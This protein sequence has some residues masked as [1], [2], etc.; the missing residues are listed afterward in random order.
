MNLSSFME[1]VYN[2]SLNVYCAFSICCDQKHVCGTSSIYVVIF[3]PLLVDFLSFSGS[4]GWWVHYTGQDLLSLGSLL[5]SWPLAGQKT[6]S[7]TFL[8]LKV[9]FEYLGRKCEGETNVDKDEEDESEEL[10]AKLVVI[11]LVGELVGVF[12]ES[13][14]DCWEEGGGSSGSPE[15]VQGRVTLKSGT[16]LITLHSMLTTIWSLFF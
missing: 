3:I 10:L 7:S 16:S 13:V 15:I 1:G 11:L 5:H 9:Q 12:H 4:T 8:V 14:W 2:Y 6:F